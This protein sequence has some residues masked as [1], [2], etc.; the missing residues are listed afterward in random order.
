MH[1]WNRLCQRWIRSPCSCRSEIML[2]CL[3][4]EKGTCTWYLPSA[5]STLSALTTLCYAVSHRQFSLW[6][7]SRVESDFFSAAAYRSWPRWQFFVLNFSSAVY[8]HQVR[9]GRFHTIFISE[10]IALNNVSK[11]SV[12]VL[13]FVL[14]TRRFSCVSGIAIF[15]LYTFFCILHFERLRSLSLANQNFNRWLLKYINSLYPV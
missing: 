9:C 4:Y 15:L 3:K 13:V 8:F 1:I 2:A 11:N 7:L 5:A 12:S 14:C 6:K 10:F